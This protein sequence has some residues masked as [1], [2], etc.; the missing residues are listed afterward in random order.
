MC[1]ICDSKCILDRSC[2]WL[3]LG[4]K[5][6]EHQERK[7]QVI[8]RQLLPTCLPAVSLHC[9]LLWEGRAACTLWTERLPSME[10]F[11]KPT[12]CCKMYRL[13]VGICTLDFIKNCPY[14]ADVCAVSAVGLLGA[15]ALQ[16]CSISALA[17]FSGPQPENWLWL[18][19]LSVP[20]AETHISPGHGLIVL[21]PQKT[22]QLDSFFAL[23]LSY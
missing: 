16:Y 10:E 19:N 17:F 9:I 14:A 12:C 6:W 8:P 4:V 23:P 7:L 5:V 21:N 2:A 1:S 20:Y 18:L 3:Y 13:F 15:V 22:V 11:L